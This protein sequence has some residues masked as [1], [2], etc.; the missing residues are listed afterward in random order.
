MTA[1]TKMTPKMLPKIFIALFTMS[2][3]ALAY[4]EE[5]DESAEPAEPAELTITDYISL[6]P[7]FVTH[8]GPPGGKLSYLK[9]SV[10]L[11]ADASTTRPAVEAHMPRIRHELVLL[12]GEQSDVDALTRPDT[13]QTLATEATARVNQVLENQHTG[14]VV[15]G[16]LFTEFVVQK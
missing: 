15:S 4:S 6:E 13:Q 10:S 7:A 3:A 16:V 5:P 11:R 1:L 8:I 9:A 14:E 2:L 12:F